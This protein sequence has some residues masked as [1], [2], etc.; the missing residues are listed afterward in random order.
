M[1]CLGVTNRLTEPL[2]RA[3]VLLVLPWP[4][5]P[6]AL[7][8][9]YRRR[10]LAAHPDRGGSNEAFIA[11]ESAREQVA[12]VLDGRLP[13][14]REPDPDPD[15][16]PEPSWQRPRYRPPDHGFRRSRRGNLWRRLPDGRAAT[17]F[18]YDRDGWHGYKW[19]VG[20][21]VNTRYGRRVYG[22]ED[23]ALAALLGEL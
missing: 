23:E 6:D 15:P 12:A 5:D 22:T 11:L 1:P 18:A 14:L 4:T 3:L 8:R 16:D 13:A 17:V 7:R 9:A 2:R 21:G 10:A 20:D 19:C